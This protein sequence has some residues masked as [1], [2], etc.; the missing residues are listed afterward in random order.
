MGKKDLSI[1][2]A[3]TCDALK[4]QIEAPVRTLDTRLHYGLFTLPDSDS[5]L[6]SKPDGYI[7]LCRNIHIGSDLDPDPCTESFPNHCCTHFR[8]RYRSGDRCSSLF[9]TFQSGDQSSDRNQCE[10]SAQYTNPSPSRD[11]SPNPVI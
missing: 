9:H 10:I 5:D 2:S 7:V 8:D 4:S 11:L 6:D 3:R 1:I